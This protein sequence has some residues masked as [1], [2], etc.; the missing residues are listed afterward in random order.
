MDFLDKLY[1]GNTIS[2]WFV[3]LLLILFSFVTGKLLYWISN[4][5]VKFLTRKTETK[6]DDILVDM[7]EEPLVVAVTFVGIRYSL[8]YLTLSDSVI[9]GTDNIFQFIMVMMLAWGIVRLYEAIHVEYLVKFAEKTATDFDDQILG[10]LRTGVRFLTISL[11]VIVGLNNAGYDVGAVLA[12]LG[13]SGLALALAAQ[14]TVSNIF[15]G[16]TVFIQRPFKVG[17]RI[18]VGDIEGSVLEIGLRSSL[19]KRVS[20][21][22][23]FLPNKIFIGEA[24]VNLAVANF[25]FQ[26]EIYR[27]HH[28]TSRE[29]VEQV[30]QLL[31]NTADEHEQ[32][33][34]S[35]PA[36]VRVS[37]YGFTLEWLYGVKPWRSEQVFMNHI[38]KMAIVRSQLNLSAMSGF[39]QHDIE[40]APPILLGGQRV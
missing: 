18:L 16:V 10:I 9:A 37:G 8:R 26:K 17:D 13:I 4:R 39:K 23:I 7:L 28:R 14:D 11:A 30:L 25:Y 12:G 3:T 6:L 22:K 33:V 40:L 31:R 27:L 38:H 5:W 32:V 2:V 21:E 29:Q 15:G 34:W 35:E 19:L 1:Y 24:V 20:G 36:L